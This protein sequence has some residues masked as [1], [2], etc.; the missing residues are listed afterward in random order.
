[1]NARL[2]SLLRRRT[3]LPAHSGRGNWLEAQFFVVCAPSCAVHQARLF[4][5]RAIVLLTRG[6]APV[7][8][9][10]AG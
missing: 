5:Q 10:I 3:V 1:M 2:A 9:V 8:R 7:L 4:R 6:R